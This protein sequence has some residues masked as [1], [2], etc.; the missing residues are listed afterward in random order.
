MKTFRK[1]C[2]VI[3]SDSTFDTMQYNPEIHFNLY[4]ND[5]LRLYFSES[6][7]NSSNVCSMWN[8][9]YQITCYTI[10]H[11]VMKMTRIDISHK[12]CFKK[13]KSIDYVKQTIK[14]SISWNFDNV[15]W[16]LWFTVGPKD[17]W[18]T[19]IYI[20]TAIKQQI[21]YSNNNL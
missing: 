17:A 19:H 6:N 9:L 8:V 20:V 3:E 12:H 16:L 10:I 2:Y 4:H 14:R 18:L 11:N 13:N 7:F 21:V 5:L 1:I 15:V